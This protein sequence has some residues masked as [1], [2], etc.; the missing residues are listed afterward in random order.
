MGLYILS[1]AKVETVHD[2]ILNPGELPGLAGDKSL[3]ATLARV[4]QRIHFGMIEDE[5]DLAAT[6]AMVIARGHCFNDGNKRTAVS[7]LLICLDVHGVELGYDRK[8]LGDKIIELASG[9]IDEQDLA[10]W[11]RKS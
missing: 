5:Y 3:E 6:Y 4:E 8:I 2:S 9:A 7:V 11:L 1:Q 10:K